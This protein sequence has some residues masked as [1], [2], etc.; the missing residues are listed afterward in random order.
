MKTKQKKIII[1]RQY[2]KQLI[3][4]L[5]IFTPLTFF[6][7]EFSFSM[8]FEDAV[9][10]KDTLVL[11]YDP[12]ASSGINLQFG[13][14]NILCEPFI[15]DLDVRTGIF[16]GWWM[17]PDSFL[18]KKHIIP[19]DCNVQFPLAG[20][21]Y[22]YCKNF[23]LKISWDPVFIDDCNK[24]SF[25]TDWEYGLWFDCIYN[26]VQ[27][28]FFMKDSAS[29]TFEHLNFYEGRE[30]LFPYNGVNLN[31]LYYSLW[32]L[33]DFNSIRKIYP[34][35][36]AIHPN[37]VEDILYIQT[38]NREFE[39]AKIRD[40]TGRIIMT[41]KKNPV[42]VSSLQKGVYILEVTIK[43]SKNVVIQKFNK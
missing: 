21:I 35:E 4:L 20:F 7:Q 25:I 30:N 15:K 5:M 18:T 3:L 24:Y 10:N 31:L 40:L 2:L 14:E 19:K 27:G 32:Y 9:G 39:Y 23:P 36:I 29:I 42:Q 41:S 22:I 1:F 34:K 8:Y 16:K 38:G 13:E 6:G 33:P 37:P 11:G 28:P 17:D 43:N 26:G 12:A